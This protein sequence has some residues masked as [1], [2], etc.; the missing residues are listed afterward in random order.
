MIIQLIL[1][2]PNRRTLESTL[3]A[4]L[5]R[6]N[7]GVIG[8]IIGTCV[9]CRKKNWY[10]YSCV[11]LTWKEAGNIWSF[12]LEMYYFKYLLVVFHIKLKDGNS[13]EQKHLQHR[14]WRFSTKIAYYEMSYYRCGF[15]FFLSTENR[16][17]HC[18]IICGECSMNWQDTLEQI[19]IQ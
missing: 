19:V 8:P 9:D 17:H 12:W 6:R 13:I 15:I 14:S 4:R 18:Y 7:C 10:Y 11:L 5:L 2:H 16:V 1:N 3:Y